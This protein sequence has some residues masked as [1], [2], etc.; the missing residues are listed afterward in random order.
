MGGG[1]HRINCD[2]GERGTGHAEDRLLLLYADIAN[3]AC[4]GHAGDAASARCF[5]ELAERRGVAVSAHLSYPDRPGFG[6][7]HL[8]I[9]EDSLLASLDEQRL[10]L[11]DVA[12]V[13]LHGALYNESCVHPGLAATLAAWMAARDVREVITV[14]EGALARSCRARGIDVIREAFAERRYC[15]EDGSG[16]PLL[17]PRDREGALIGDIEEALAQSRDILT[18]GAV[19]AVRC[20]SCGGDAVWVA[21]GADT[22]CIHSDSPIAVPLA[23]RLRALVSEETT[24]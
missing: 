21:V 19:R 14:A 16:L 12:L 24:E 20:G 15:V 9:P 11:P 22:L 23:R 2:I 4:G 6:R 18:R 13:K 7:R 5:Q 17:L 10:L 1:R 8:E 3:I